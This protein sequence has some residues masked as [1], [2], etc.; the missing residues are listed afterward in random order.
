MEAFELD[1][2]V[3][4]LP[5]NQV[6]WQEFLRSPALSM[7]IYR[8][9]VGS[10]DPQ[11]PHSEDEV[12]LVHSGHGVIRVGSEDRSVQPGTLVYVRALVEHRFHSISEEL[13]VL[14]F[15]AP[16]EYTNRKEEGGSQTSD[17]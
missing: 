17:F 16:A 10:I 12:Y 14:V 8:L 4:P 2:L 7:G 6:A 9:P 3:E 13:T 5:R 15:F 11:K 1:A